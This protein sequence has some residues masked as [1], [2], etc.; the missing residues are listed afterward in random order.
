[1]TDA[2]VVPGERDVRGSVEAGDANTCVV[3]CPPHPQYGGSRRD[4]RLRAVSSSLADRGIACLRFDYGPWAD[5]LGEQ[6][7]V[8]NAVAWATSR[9]ESVGVFGYSFGGTMALLVAPTVSIDALSLLA[10]PVSV[11][12]LDADTVAAV[13]A[14]TGP[15]Q[16]IYGARD[17]TVDSIPIAERARELGHSV[18]EM[19]ADHFFIGNESTIGET[20]AGFFVGELIA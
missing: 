3:A 6:S 19:P 1:M 7:D 13:E 17:S 18:V 10:P 2:V 9:F 8:E 4:G 11:S 12:G 14:F 15:I 20:V 16:V 5:G